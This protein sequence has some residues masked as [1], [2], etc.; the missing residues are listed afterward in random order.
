MRLHFLVLFILLFG[1][2]SSFS[3][4]L[5]D[6]NEMILLDV[7]N[8]QTNISRISMTS[9]NGWAISNIAIGSLA[10]DG[11]QGKDRYFHQMNVFW[12][13]VNLSIGIP[14]LIKTYKDRPT[15]FE[16]TY[17]YQK[18]LENVYLFNMGLDLGYVASGWALDNFGKTRTGDLG[19]RFKGYGN[20]LVLQGSYLFV[21]DLILYFLYKSNNDRLDLVWKNVTI[22]PAG[23]GVVIE[24]N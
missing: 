21:H 7:N 16:S 6:T 4:P 1:T 10:F 13:V 8:R 5:A 20:S 17:K 18:K 12:N 14:G 23:I 3:Q 24:L 11:A 2:Q 19:D 15:D 22:K 9:L